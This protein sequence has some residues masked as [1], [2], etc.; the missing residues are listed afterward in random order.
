MSA[1]PCRA[2]GGA[3][4]GVGQDRGWGR[5]GGG[6]GQGVGQGRGWG[7]AGGGERVRES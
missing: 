5:A 7:R 4:Q 6:A 1:I 3:G 2:G